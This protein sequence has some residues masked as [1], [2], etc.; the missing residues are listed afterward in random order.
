MKIMREQFGALSVLHELIITHEGTVKWHYFTVIRSY[1]KN[2]FK[3][4][5]NKYLAY[6]D[7]GVYLEVYTL[8]GRA[9]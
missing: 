1:V 2:V 8:C 3:L 6:F 9:F 7:V 4:S 5:Y